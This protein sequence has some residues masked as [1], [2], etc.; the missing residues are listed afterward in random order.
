M[1]CCVRERGRE[2]VGEGGMGREKEERQW[3]EIER[4]AILHVYTCMYVLRW[5]RGRNVFPSCCN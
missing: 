5:S 3:R 2:G 4:E 1:L